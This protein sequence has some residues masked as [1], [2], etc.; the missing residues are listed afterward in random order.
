MIE[1]IKSGESPRPCDIE[2]LINTY[3]TDLE[4]IYAKLCVNSTASSEDIFSV[5]KHIKPTVLGER[6]QSL[7]ICFLKVLRKHSYLLRDHPHLWFQ[8]VINEGP[9]ELSSRAAT[10]MEN[11]LPTVPYMKYLD[12]KEENGAVQARFYCS[13]TVACF[14]VSPDMDYMVCE[15]RDGTIHM[16]SLK[17]GNIEWIRPSLIKREYHGV[18]PDY[19][20]YSDGGAYRGIDFK[21]LTFYRSVVFHPS[22]KY[23]LPG[24]LRSVYTLDGDC[25]YLF[26]QSNC[27]FSHC[28]F[29]REKRIIL[30]DCCDDPKKVVLW[31]ME[32]GQELKIIAWKNDITAFAISH[33]GTLVAFADL[34][35]YIYLVDVDKW[36]GQYLFKRKYAACG[37]LHFTTDNEAL[38]CGY[39]PYRVEDLGYH[40]YGWASQKE[41]KFLLL[42]FKECL[43][44]S[45]S[46]GSPFFLER[47]FFLWPI[48][49]RTLTK[50][51]LSDDGLR[52]IWVDNVRLVF[53]SLPAGFYKKLSTE[54]AL[55]GSPSLKYVVAV[56]LDLSNDVNSAS[57]LQ[58]VEKVELCSEG[59]TIYCVSLEEDEDTGRVILVTVY[60]M[61]TREVLAKK[62]FTC[63]SLCLVPMKE[64]VI[65]CLKDQVPELWNFE[66]T[67]CVRPIAR[68]T[69]A[70]TSA[71]LLPEDES[72]EQDV[73]ES[74][75]EGDSTFSHNSSNLDISLGSSDINQVMNCL[76]MLMISNRFELY[77]MLV[78]DIVSVTNGE[79]VS[80]IKTRVCRGED[81]LFISCNSQNQLLVCTI[82][83]VVE[84]SISVEHFT[85]SLRNNNLP[86]RV[87]ERSEKRLEGPFQPCFRFS[88]EEQF[89]TTWGSF[90]SGYGVHILD[91]KTGETRHSLLT[92]QDD[93]VDCKFVVNDES[94]VCCSKDNFL[95]L[96]N[97]R[98]GDLLSVLDIE[99]QP[100]YLG[101]CLDKP[102]VAIGL[103]GARLKFVH[104]ELLSV[105][106]AEGKTGS[107]TKQK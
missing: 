11:R 81:V 76:T 53:P 84:P 88:P 66:L 75:D 67:E 56:D 20:L 78:V 15:C 29:P 94:L 26:R 82:E 18:H 90:Y 61:S 77:R 9:P 10:I 89:V 17:T 28:A 49:P 8:S 36:H 105:Q 38:V 83:F 46:C 85:V 101:T 62:F 44:F 58:V 48:K 6:S 106:D 102:L 51:H 63:P 103:L 21:V 73:D 7:L 34:P 68:L 71:D 12:K 95:R 65:L 24:S 99:E 25:N 40:Q 37:L 33:D 70:E 16:W 98:S 86:R 92:D 32:N 54:T 55:V 93:I 100:Q 79:C 91:A 96:F 42:E 41:P 19:S 59:D 4:L 22:G 39:L 31:S 60:R 74:V 14:D 35:G 72:V 107:L 23:V 13:D 64:G 104:V 43:S 3:V 97:I 87:W 52:S 30:T 1:L 27:V 45:S 2:E 5:Q 50:N 47:K 80:S 69:V 57:T